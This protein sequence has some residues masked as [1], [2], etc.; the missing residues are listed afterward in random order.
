ML[1]STHP[2]FARIK[3]EYLEIV[4]HFHQTGFFLAKD[5]QMVTENLASQLFIRASLLKILGTLSSFSLLTEPEK[6]D[7]YRVEIIKRSLA[8]IRS[9]YQEKLYIRDLAQQANMNEQY[10]C[11]FFKKALGKSPVSYINEYRIKQA[12]ILLQTTDLPV[13]DICLDCGFHNLG[14][15]LREFKKDTGFTP[16]QY[17]KHFSPKKS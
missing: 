7:H 8:Y 13:M 1:E 2:A 15:F 6:T 10:F 5:I 3:Q 9:H 4:N 12:I 11:R 14:N 17:R 16:L